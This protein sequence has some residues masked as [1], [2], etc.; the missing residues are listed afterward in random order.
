M[1]VINFQRYLIFNMAATNKRS[2]GKR[3]PYD[4]LNNLSSVDLFYDEKSKKKTASKKVLGIYAAERLIARN[5]F[6][7]L[8]SFFLRIYL[9]KNRAWFLN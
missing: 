3:V 6:Y 9:Q 7:V 2:E 4:I 5:F 8:Y 1:P